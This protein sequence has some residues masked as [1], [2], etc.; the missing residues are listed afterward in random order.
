MTDVSEPAVGIFFV[1]GDELCIE[2]TPIS[3][4][5]P[6]GDDFRIHPG[7]HRAFWEEM[8]RAKRG[9]SSVPY[10]FYP[11]G[12][13][14]FSANDGRFWVYA[15]RST[16]EDRGMIVNILGEFHLPQ[17]NTKIRCD[18]QYKCGVCNPH[19]VPDAVGLDI[20]DYLP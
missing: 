1:I 4:A 16:Y 10:D 20:D 12:R 8:R 15:D 11:R 6:Y 7:N 14:V 9:L 13:V 2:S 19:Y 18:P 5:E 3:A 17:E